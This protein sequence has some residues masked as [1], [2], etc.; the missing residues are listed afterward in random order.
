[1]AAKQLVGA[2][3]IAGLAVFSVRAW[4]FSDH[5]S[6][7]VLGPDFDDKVNDG[8]VYFVKFFAPW[9]GHCK[10]LGPAWKG[11][12]EYFK[13]H[14][15]IRIAHVDCTVDRAV[16]DTAGVSL[17]LRQLQQS[18]CPLHREPHEFHL[19]LQE[20]HVLYNGH[21]CDIRPTTPLWAAALLVFF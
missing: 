12:A 6:I 5:G 18:H 11:L 10:H 17:W 14:D 19:V 9:C 2:L 20:T 3:L 1:M 15:N 21:Y 4:D 8:H 13:E 16:C 7:H